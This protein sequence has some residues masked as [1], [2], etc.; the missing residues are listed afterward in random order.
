MLNIPPSPKSNILADASV[1]STFKIN[2]KLN[3]VPKSGGEA[4]SM[5]PAEPS[6]WR[7]APSQVE[8]VRLDVISPCVG[9]ALISVK[10]AIS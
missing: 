10:S 6:K 5:F 7:P 9:F 1:L 2:S 4:M 8:P 3:L